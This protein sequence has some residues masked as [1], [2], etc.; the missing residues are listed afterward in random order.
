MS[1]QYL[2]LYH[3]HRQL[4]DS[5]SVP[6]FNDKRGAAAAA[7]ERLGLPSQKV[8]RFKYTDIRSAFEP[9]YGLNL[10]RLRIPVNPYEA[11]RCD[12]PNLST[13][14][15]FVVNDSFY[16]DAQPKASLPDGVVVD[17]LCS[18]QSAILAA[19]YFATLADVNT[20]AVAALNTMLSQD[21]LLI[22]V[23][24]SVCIER[25]IQVVNIM[26]GDVPLMAN[27]RILVVAEA[28]SHVRI[29][30]C[31]HAADEQ[32]F[33]STQVTEVFV[34]EGAEVEFYELEETHA[35]CHRFAQFYSDVHASGRLTHASITL[36]CGLTRNQTDVRLVGRGAEANLLGCAIS[37]AEQHIDNNTL[38]EHSAPACSSH[39]LYKYVVDQQSTGAFAGRILVH[40]EAQQTDSDE[41]NANLVCTP[42]ARM[43]TQPMLEIYSDDVKCSH[44]STVGQLSDEALFY[45][46]Q[47]GIS[48]ADAR[49][50][51][52]QAF[53]S[54]VIDRISLVPLR[55]RLHLLIDKRFRGELAQCRT[56]RLCGR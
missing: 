31:D 17:S 42:Q 13:S 49:L 50:L 44:G 46:L 26:R 4:L 6:L 45:M 23:P 37:D 3:Q 1:N 36:S 15:Y 24:A 9:D 55:D 28:N 8:E 53:A 47:R 20:D 16:R 19:P 10:S 39:E 35:R 52:K 48:E 14:V 33:L 34:G 38:I 40:E 21:G 43:Y 29:L 18:D 12:V 41:R 2:T 30:L 54:E 5:H 51:L 7:F 56:C 11:F 22:Y 32:D 27:R 25:P